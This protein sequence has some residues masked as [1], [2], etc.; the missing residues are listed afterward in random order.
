MNSDE[1]VVHLADALARHVRLS[2]SPAKLHELRLIAELLTRIASDGQDRPVS[3]RQAIEVKA[4]G[5]GGG[6]KLAFDIP[7]V[8]AA[9]SVSERTAR[10]LVDDGD[11]PSVK[12]RD[13]RLVRRVDLE[14]YVASRGA[15]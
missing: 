6:V 12:V 7:A 10:R 8:A 1:F 13:R 5:D 2:G 4:A 15:A 11:I 3:F 9:L 14:A